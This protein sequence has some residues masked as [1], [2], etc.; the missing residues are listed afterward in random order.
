MFNAES[1]ELPSDNELGFC[2]GIVSAD[3]DGSAGPYDFVYIGAL[4]SAGNQNQGGR[5]RIG[6]ENDTWSNGN[7]ISPTAGSM[8]HGTVVVGS[9]SN[10]N[11]IAFSTFESDGSSIGYDIL[12]TTGVS[13]PG[14]FANYHWFFA[15]AGDPHGTATLPITASYV[16]EASFAKQNFDDRVG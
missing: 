15:L 16:C 12:A 2:F 6:R 13:F 7:A 8:L 9:G 11:F 1:G 3:W 5:F 14:N 10:P 4:G